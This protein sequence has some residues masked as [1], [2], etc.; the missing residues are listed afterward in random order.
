MEQRQLEELVRA[1]T[2]ELAEQTADRRPRFSPANRRPT[3]RPSRVAE[4]G[5]T[6]DVGGGGGGTQACWLVDNWRVRESEREAFLDYYRRYV[7]EVM[8]T[9]PGFRSGRIVTSPSGASYTWHVQAFYEFES[10]A[11]RDNFAR[12]FDRAV[13]RVDPRMSLEKV[14]DGMDQW[15]L[16]HE[17]GALTEV[18]RTP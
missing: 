13:K 7:A 2:R 18:W 16:A 1:I 12:D 15:V 14:L 4:R 17:D 9:L 10:D 6:R 11:V 8:A 5:R 3:V